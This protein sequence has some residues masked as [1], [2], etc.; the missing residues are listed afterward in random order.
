MSKIDLNDVQ[1]GY[2]LSQI[3]SNFQKLEDA[4]NENILWRDL[5]GSQDANQMENPLDMNGNAIYNLPYA[6]SPHEPVTLAQLADFSAGTGGPIAVLPATNVTY[7]P[8]TP[9][10][11]NTVQGALDQLAQLTQQ[12]VPIASEVSITPIAGMSSAN[13]QQALEEINTSV[14]ALQG[15]TSAVPVLNTV[16]EL[17][18]YVRGTKTLVRIQN[19]SATGDGGGGLYGYA[20]AIT[21]DLNGGVVLA[22][23]GGSWVLVDAPTAR[24]FGARG[25]STNDTVALQNALNFAATFRRSL[26]IPAGRY[27]VSQLIYFHTY[28]ASISVTGDGQ[29]VTTIEHIAGLNSNMFSLENMGDPSAIGPN[30]VLFKGIHF[31]GNFPDTKPANTLNYTH[32]T[33]Y[34][35][36]GF[37]NTFVGCRFS[38]GTFGFSNQSGVLD[39]FE[40]CSFD[41]NFYG[42]RVYGEIGTT[43]YVLNSELKDNYLYG[44]HVEDFRHVVLSL[45]SV[46]ANGGVAEGA[47]VFVGNTVGQHQTTGLLSR[48]VTLRDCWLENNLGTASVVFASGLNS[49]Q[50]CIFSNQQTANTIRVSG[51]RYHFKDNLFELPATAH[52]YEEK[53]SLVY[54]GNVVLDCV[55]GTTKTP[56]VCD[57]DPL[58]TR[59]A[60]DG[61][62]GGGG[63]GT[64]DVTGPGSAVENNIA[65]YDGTTGKFI[66][67]AGTSVAALQASIAGKQNTLVAGVNI[68]TIDGLSPLGP[69]NIDTGGGGGG[70]LKPRIVV[71]GDSLSAKSDMLAPAWPELLEQQLRSYGAD[72]EVHNLAIAGHSFGLAN[73]PYFGTMS[74][75]TKAID[76]EP[77]VVIV[78]LGLNDTLIGGGAFP[79]TV[80]GAIDSTLAALRAGLPTATILYASIE[81]WDKTHNPSGTSVTNRQSAPWLMQRPF[82]GPAQGKWC[83]EM[84]DSP[85]RSDMQANIPKWIAMDAYLKPHGN[86]DGFISLSHFKMARLGLTG[87]DSLHPSAEGSKFL[88]AQVRKGLQANSSF[89]AKFPD[90]RTWVYS[91]WEDPDTVFAEFCT[92]SGGNYINAA[93]KVDGAA[94]WLAREH[95]S[96]HALNLHS[97]RTDTWFMPTKGSVGATPTTVPALGILTL[98]ASTCTPKMMAKLSVDYATAIDI[99]LVTD[100][101][102]NGVLALPA[103]HNLAGTH[104]YRVIIADEM[105]GPFNITI[106][107]TT[108]GNVT[109]PASSV[110]NRIATFSGAT[111]KIIADSGR[112]VADIDASLAGKQATLVSGSNI[113]TIN[114]S[115]L[116][117]SGN[118]VV[119]GQ[120]LASSN[121]T[122]IPA[123]TIAAGSSDVAIGSITIP[124]SGLLI[125]N[126]SIGGNFTATSGRIRTRAVIAGT[127]SGT[128]SQG[129]SAV[130]GEYATSMGM[131]ATGVAAGAVVTIYASTIGSAFNVT[132]PN[133]AS[134]ISYVLLPFA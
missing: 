113:R 36:T 67:D 120:P 121:W 33:V 43:T 57:V 1:G 26:H 89:T 58:K 19:H 100:G 24:H 99:P 50:G 130:A 94:G 117:G 73:T 75:V 60:Y 61:S 124:T 126:W 91:I 40:H 55:V 97:I 103:W 35:K 20:G 4:M 30:G 104:L 16:A 37:I 90:M 23:G 131:V 96:A 28:L 110:N 29:G 41:K 76:L 78:A 38:H 27:L 45:C 9:L 95:V 49:I 107:T 44:L 79:G 11:A 111:G 109:G 7:V 5:D 115:S 31:K 132:S 69:G 119:G 12:S 93:R 8:A 85:I 32:A 34:M 112:T 22:V 2:N 39:R 53:T 63:G 65:V 47:G 10:T 18:A 15:G 105:Y 129:S 98:S 70:S 13:V 125:L 127:P 64:G 83:S 88:A 82:S 6:T 62:G 74:Q 17:R 14:T 59:T 122:T 72:V 128:G 46:E 52:V 106:D 48:G 68:K 56:P 114:G 42:L 77:V 80:Q 133:N 3:N 71:I 81:P 92:S 101:S 108:P 116:L 87:L 54:S 84:L 134:A 123:Q 66:K 25:Q 21:A 118:L 102:G 51:G 86:L